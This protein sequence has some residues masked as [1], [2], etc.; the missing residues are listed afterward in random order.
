MINMSLEQPLIIQLM[1][2]Y[3]LVWGLFDGVKST[4]FRIVV[5]FTKDIFIQNSLGRFLGS[6]WYVCILLVTLYF[7]GI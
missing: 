5:L 2:L 4:V 7:L 6:V 3:V 1:I